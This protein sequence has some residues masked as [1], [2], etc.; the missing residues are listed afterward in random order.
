MKDSL[1]EIAANLRC[2][3]DALVC[4]SNNPGQHGAFSEP[5][6]TAIQNCD[7]GLE[8]TAKLLRVFPVNGAM[9]IP[10]SP[11]RVRVPPGVTLEIVNVR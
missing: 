11:I 8:L 10:Q 9:V 5:W 2:A 6:F 7:E 4:A 3:R 1:T